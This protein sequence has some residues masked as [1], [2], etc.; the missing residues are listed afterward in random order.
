[1]KVT[2]ASTFGGNMIL[3][4]SQNGNTKFELFNTTNGSA[5]ETSLVLTSSNG[6][7]LFSKYSASKTAYK[8]VS[9]GDA[10]MYNATNGNISILNDFATG[11][12]KFGAGGS[13]TA[14]MT[15]K[16]N[17]T[18]NMSSLPTSSTGLATGDLWNDAGT[19]KI[20]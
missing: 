15:I 1:M 7:F 19:I 11:T 10:L 16:A 18:I 9:S 6:L 2:G 3:N 17:G 5:S 20:V 4:L 12:I 13:S 8:F 14:H